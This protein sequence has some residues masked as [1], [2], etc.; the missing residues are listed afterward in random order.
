MAQ[1]VDKGL[2]RRAVIALSVAVLGFLV[3]LLGHGLAVALFV[4]ALLPGCG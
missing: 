1:S 2:P 3:T 4:L